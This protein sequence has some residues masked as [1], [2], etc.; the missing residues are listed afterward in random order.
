M[1]SVDDLV[2]RILESESSALA[3]LLAGAYQFLGDANRAE[4]IVDA[5]RTAGIEFAPK[6]PFARFIR[7]EMSVDWTKQISAT[8]TYNL[9]LHMQQKVVA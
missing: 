3:S 2:R 4:Q 6:N 8:E 9:L 7:E 5:A 1:K